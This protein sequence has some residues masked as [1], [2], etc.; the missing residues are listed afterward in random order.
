M[1]TIAGKIAYTSAHAICDRQTKASHH[2]EVLKKLRKTRDDLHLLVDT[3]VT[4]SYPVELQRILA[5]IP[6]LSEQ[7]LWLYHIE[8]RVLIASP[9]DRETR[10]NDALGPDFLFQN[11]DQMKKG[12]EIML[13]FQKSMRSPFSASKIIPHEKLT[14]YQMAQL[15]SIGGWS[16]PR[17]IVLKYIRGEGTPELFGKVHFQDREDPKILHLCFNLSF[18]RITDQPEISNF[19][20]IH[21]VD[22]RKK[23]NHSLYDMVFELQT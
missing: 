8:E 21:F 9:R 13:T 18:R 14:I 16:L 10:I 20:N 3:Y 23:N 11:L 15:L 1:F 4:R 7:R 22:F 2:R 5:G 17:R 12:L 19:G 6:G